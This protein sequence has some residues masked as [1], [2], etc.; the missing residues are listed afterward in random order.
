MRTKNEAINQRAVKDYD[1]I[2]NKYK[3][4]LPSTG[5]IQ[6][7]ILEKRKRILSKVVSITLILFR[8]A[9]PENEEPTVSVPGKSKKEV[10]TEAKQDLA[11]VL[12]KSAKAKRKYG[13]LEQFYIGSFDLR[14]SADDEEFFEKME[15]RM[16]RRGGTIES[17]EASDFKRLTSILKVKK[18]CLP[19]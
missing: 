15:N 11:N 18:W 2:A 9:T 1:K 7:Q 17:V 19:T 5:R 12:S 8:L 13:K 10:I 4:S 6:R 3:D 14:V 16:T